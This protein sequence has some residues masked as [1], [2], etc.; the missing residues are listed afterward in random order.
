VGAG[1]KKSRAMQASRATVTASSNQ[2]PLEDDIGAAVE[3][4]GGIAAV[5]EAGGV[6]AVEAGGGVMVSAGAIVA[7]GAAAVEEAAAP[8]SF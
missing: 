3:E 6:I 4:A 5:E 7:A 2:P 1:K 8:L